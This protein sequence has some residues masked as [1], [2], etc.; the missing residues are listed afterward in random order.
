MK[1]IINMSL[2]FAFS[3]VNKRIDYNVRNKNNINIIKSRINVRKKSFIISAYMLWNELLD[4]HRTVSGYKCFQ[5]KV[6]S[7]LIAQ[8]HSV[9]YIFFYYIL[10]FDYWRILYRNGVRI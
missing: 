7:F 6:N 9:N 4:D 5:S 8:Y 1:K 2:N 3:Y 10:Y